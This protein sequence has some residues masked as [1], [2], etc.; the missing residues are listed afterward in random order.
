MITSFDILFKH[1]LNNIDNIVKQNRQD[2]CTFVVK[3]YHLDWIN[4]IKSGLLKSASKL[5]IRV[6]SCTF[7]VKA[8]FA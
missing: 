4:R 6:Y 8:G 2:V 7:V 1:S 5:L 3:T